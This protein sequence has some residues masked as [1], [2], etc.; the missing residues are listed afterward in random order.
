MT[1]DPFGAGLAPSTVDAGSPDSGRP[2]ESG[3]GR[4][5]HA[6]AQRATTTATTNGPASARNQLRFESRARA[7]MATSDWRVLRAGEGA[8]FAEPLFD[9]PRPQR[10]ERRERFA[11]RNRR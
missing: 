11:R 8:G 3:F 5:A 10:V 2:F 4:R 7:V 1:V 9:E 6:I